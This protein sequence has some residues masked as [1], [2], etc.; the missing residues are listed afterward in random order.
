M[1]GFFAS[2]AAARKN[3]RR[4]KT[5]TS[6]MRFCPAL[7]RCMTSMRSFEAATSATSTMSMRNSLALCTMR[8]NRQRL[9]ACDL[10]L[11]NSQ[12]QHNDGFNR[13][14]LSMHNCTAD[15]QAVAQ[16][17]ARCCT[18]YKA[19]ELTIKSCSES[20]QRRERIFTD[21]AATVILILSLQKIPPFLQKMLIVLR[22][23][24]S[25]YENAFLFCC[26]FVLILGCCGVSFIKRNAC[27]FRC[28]FAP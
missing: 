6:H 16:A 23:S 17:V 13:L 4:L 24:I 12:T 8:P 7:M 27:S 21:F 28:Y 1:T 26:I 9:F 22:F 2:C 14:C 18:S 10:Q 5:A 19:A 20:K 25:V 15:A 3:L 11:F